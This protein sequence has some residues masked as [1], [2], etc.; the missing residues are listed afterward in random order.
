MLRNNK[1]F[2][3]GLALLMFCQCQASFAAANPM[4]DLEESAQDFVLEIKKIQIPGFPNAFNPSIIRWKG[5][6][7]MS[8]RIIPDI[9]NSYTS[10]IGLIWLDEDFCPIGE[11]QILDTTLSPTTPSRTDDG[12]IVAVGDQIYLVYSDNTDP[13][14]SKGGF[15]VFV[16]KLRFDGGLFHVENPVKLSQFDGEIKERRE[17]NW[18]PFDYQGQLLLAYSLAPHVIFRPLLDTGACETVAYSSSNWKWQWGEPRGGSP[19]LIVGEDYLSFFHSSLSTS[20]LHSDGRKMNHY[21]MGAYTF[22]AQPPFPIKRV[23]PEPIV[24]KGFYRGPVY[25]P[26]WGSVRCVYPAGFI[27]DDNFIWVSYGRQDHE[28]WIAKLDKKELLNSLVPVS[29]AE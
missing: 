17:K 11:P 28:V 1:G 3:W 19:A 12:R 29:A 18:V 5:L 22:S 21:F 7:L 23:S 26:Y 24:G 2:R 27:F 8:F 6:I 25:K 13:E 16:A 14:I 4:I 9:K 20:T 15:R 10:Q